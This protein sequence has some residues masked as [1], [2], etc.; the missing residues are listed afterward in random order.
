MI[1]SHTVVNNDQQAL[2]LQIEEMRGHLVKMVETS[3]KYEVKLDSKE[4]EIKSLVRKEKEGR[5]ETHHLCTVIL[6]IPYSYFCDLDNVIEKMKRDKGK[7]QKYQY[8]L[9]IVSH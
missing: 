9:H 8:V 7:F 1:D 2:M 5:E 4:K 3:K 6:S